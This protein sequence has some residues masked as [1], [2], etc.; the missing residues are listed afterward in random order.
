MIARYAG[1][2]KAEQMFLRGFDADHGTDVAI[3]PDGT[4]VNMVTHGHGQGYADLRFV[5][6]EVID[7]ADVLKGPD[8]ARDGDASQAGGYVAGSYHVTN[9]TID[10]FGALDP[11]EGGGTERHDAGVAL[12]TAFGG[13]VQLAARHAA[14]ALQSAG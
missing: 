12:R 13:V 5:M 10:R 3:S 6:P 7:H 4:P 14:R 8:D 11:T 9:G 2:G 1:G